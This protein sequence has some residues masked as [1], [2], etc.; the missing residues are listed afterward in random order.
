MESVPVFIAVAFDH[1]ENNEFIF[2]S[3]EIF[4]SRDAAVKYCNKFGG[5]DV[6]IIPGVVQDCRSRVNLIDGIIPERRIV[7]SGAGAY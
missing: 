1:G 3:A 6:T 4:T 7:V 2:H 5:A